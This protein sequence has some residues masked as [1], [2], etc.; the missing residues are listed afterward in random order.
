[1]VYNDQLVAYYST[2]ADTTYAQKLAHKTTSDGKT[3]STEVNDVAQPTY[4][5]RPGMMT[6]AEM[7]NGQYIMTYEYC[8]TESCDIY[9]RISD[10]PLTFDSATDHKLTATN[11]A[12][13][14]GSPYVVWSSSGGANGTLVATASSHTQV[15]VNTA[16]GDPGQWVEYD[17]PQSGAYSRHL[18]IMDD[19]DYLLIMSA[20]YLSSDNWVT[21]SVMSLP[22]L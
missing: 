22:N 13:P 6:V 7:G 21:L 16:L 5:A 10:S 8:G 3:W 12:Q 11:G 19:P 18:R 4:A 14:V 9:Y 2:Q 20:G 1:M 17:T 15:F